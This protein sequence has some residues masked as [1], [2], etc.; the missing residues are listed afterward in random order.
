MHVTDSALG[1]ALGPLVPSD[2]LAYGAV[3]LYL[4]LELLSHLDGDRDQALNLFGHAKQVASL[5]QVLES[6]AYPAK[7]VQR[8]RKHTVN[9]DQ[10]RTRRGSTPIQRMADEFHGL[11]LLG[12][13]ATAGGRGAPGIELAYNV[14]SPHEVEHVLADAERA[15][16]TIVRPTAQATWGGTTEAFADPDGYVWEVAHN[17]RWTINPDG[18]I[19]I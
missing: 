13:W 6:V 5:A 10:R 4:G 16:R 11:P 1:S 3:A 12:Q 18:S 9:A 7:R 17:P 2:D 15:G 8:R 19:Q 14:C